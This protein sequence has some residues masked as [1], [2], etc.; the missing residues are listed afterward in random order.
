MNYIFC[1]IISFIC[2]LLSK[3]VDVYGSDGK[4]HIVKLTGITYLILI[5]GKANS[6][7]EEVISN[8]RSR[9]EGIGR[10]P[11]TEICPNIIEAIEKNN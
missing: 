11:T 2:I 6:E 3:A 9:R 10:K 7:N 1:P 4:D 8:G 5:A